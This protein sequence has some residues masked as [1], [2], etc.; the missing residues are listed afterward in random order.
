[1]KLIQEINVSP[2]K[3]FGL[4]KAD[5]VNVG[6]SGIEEDRRLFLIDNR[7]RLVTQ[8]DVGRLTQLKADYRSEQD[9]FC[10][11]IPGADRMEG[12][13]ETG[14]PVT[15]KLWGR[16]VTGLV[17]TGD[18]GNALS[19]FCGQTVRLVLS[20]APGQCFDE[21]P[22]SL[23]SQASLEMLN[24]QGD[25]SVDLDVRRFR[26]NFL[27]G[28]CEPH[29]EDTWLGQTIQIGHEMLLHV[30]ARD[31]RCVITCLD[32]DTGDA[33]FETRGLITRYRPSSG[34]AYFGVYGIVERA[35]DVSVGDKVQ[36]PINASS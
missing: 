25:V 28:G 1:M 6:M 2:V 4:A 8:R 32:P 22:I 12:Q 17:V 20:S 9:R 13:L 11:D 33:D 21:Y 23:L 15:T 30:V 26:P 18:W 24:G 36:T 16:D 27:I 10:L 5:V 31:P 35:G 29:E 19:H 34:T 7:D 3:S 14:E